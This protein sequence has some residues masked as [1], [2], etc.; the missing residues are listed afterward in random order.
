MRGRAL[1]RL[2]LA[3]VLAMSACSPTTAPVPAD[4]S[5]PAPEDRGTIADSRISV[6]LLNFFSSIGFGETE[7]EHPRQEEVLARLAQAGVTHVEPVDYMGF[8]GLTAAEYRALLDEYDLEVSSLHTTVTSTT[9]DEQW[10]DA[11][12]TASALGSPYL[13]GG[14]T[15]EDLT[16]SAEWIAFAELIFRLGAT[17]GAE[18]VQYLVHLHDWEYAPLD[19]GETPFEILL[20]HTSPDNV[21][22]ELDLY[23]AVAAGEDPVALID[24]H[25][26]RIALLHVKDMAA[27]GAITTVGEGTIDFPAVFA[28]AGNR[29]GSYVVERD[30]PQDDPAFDP[31]EPTIAGVRYL[32]TVDF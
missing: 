29:I 19:S 12:A 16:T 21:V 30:P 2:A 13:G 27:D 10:A 8:Q 23:W 9:S 7:A 6:Q 22:V 15:P 24:E 18:G 1:G 32:Q 5:A 20:E 25:G 14:S 28:A 17:A 31:F 26:D 11:L 3:A 4:P